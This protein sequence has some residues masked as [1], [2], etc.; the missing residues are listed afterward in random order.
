MRLSQGEIERGFAH[1]SAKLLS[2]VAF[3]Q[4]LAEQLD[5]VRAERFGD[6]NELRDIHLSLMALDHAHHR[7]GSFQKRRE[8]ALREVFTFARSR[9]DSG[10]GPSRSASQ[11]FQVLCAPIY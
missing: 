6:R 3:A 7:M 8:I 5:R 2:G 10:Y 4:H 11:G 9:E 1:N